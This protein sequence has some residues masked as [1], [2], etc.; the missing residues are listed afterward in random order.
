MKSIKDMSVKELRAQRKM[1]VRDRAWAGIGYA[2]FYENQ[3]RQVD[4]ELA[5]RKRKEA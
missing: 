5:K 3:I 4:K 2:L 1:L